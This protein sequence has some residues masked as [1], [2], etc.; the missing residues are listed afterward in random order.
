MA[1]LYLIDGNSLLFRAYY[2]TAYSGRLMQNSKGLYTN[3][4]YG[5]VNMMQKLINEGMDNVFVSFD[6][7]KQTFRHQMYDEYKA[8]RKHM[9]EEF[10][11]QLPYIRQY[12]DIVKICHYECLDFEGDDLIATVAKLA[13]DDYDDIRVITGDHDL[14]QLVD[15]KIKVMLTKK[16]IGELDEMN[17]DNFFEKNGFYPNQVTDY[18]GIAGDSS[19]HLLGV[20]GVGDKTAK[21]LLDQY[22]SL[23]GILG[24]LELLK[25]KQ[26]ELFTQYADQ[27]KMCQYLATLRKDA[28]SS[29][30]G[31]DLKRGTP[32]QKELLDFLAEMEFKSLANRL[33]NSD[34]KE[35][36]VVEINQIDLGDKWV[37]F[38][39]ISTLNEYN[40]QVLGV[41]IKNKAGSHFYTIEEIKANTSLLKDLAD[42]SIEKMTH[43]GKTTMISLARQGITLRGITE[44]S[45]LAAYLVN[46]SFADLDVTMCANHLSV[47]FSAL[48][49]EEI[50]MGSKKGEYSLD[51]I[52]TYALA[53]VDSYGALIQTLNQ[54]LQEEGAMKLYQ[55]EKELSQVLAAMEWTGLKVDLEKLESV[56]QELRE[57]ANELEKEIYNL[58]G[59]EFN[60][61]SPK[62]LSEVLFEKLGL[63]HGKKNK[64]GSF[65]TDVNVLQKL[66]EY[67]PIC[68]KILEYRGKEKLVQTYVEG[69]KSFS[70]VHDFIHP[71]YRQALT[72]TGR[73]SSVDPNIQNMPARTEEGQ[74]IR[75]VFV[76]RFPEGKIIDCDYSQ[77]ELRILAHLSEDP[78]MLEAFN[79]GTDFHASTASQIFDIPLEEVTKDMRRKAKIVNFGVI[80]GISS[81][82]LSDRLGM[83]NEEASEFI[84][85]YWANFAVAKRY[86]DGLVTTAQEKGYSETMLGRR[87][88]IP[89]LTSS[90]HAL[91]QFGERT[92]MNTPIQGSAADFIKVAMNKVQALLKEG[93]YKTVMIAQVHDELVFDSPK[94]E[95][96]I[97]M[98]LIKNC[99]ENA[100]P[101]KV[102]MAAES[103]IGANW[104]EA[105]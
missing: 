90:N 86:L 64:T 101:L 31:F 21:K 91:Q 65:K 42:A 44:D 58:A 52:K 57:K 50:F 100:M 9:P 92:A 28:L 104:L 10:A 13:Y 66:A 33:T 1:T 24:H 94:E 60:I 23:E 103:A 71:L 62:Q 83:S 5:F 48:H 96:E 84:N 77:I 4:I 19:D 102:K 8:G 39:V 20:P 40:G 78:K 56:G 76:S 81:W 6:A 82:G 89:K 15:K 25:G 97:V 38:P 18:K 68:A 3:A 36:K 72:T 88:Y 2:A 63:P 54:A 74:V 61:A 79:S 99:M 32:D 37:V 73:L 69:I 26:K 46:P 29:L 7:G 51:D 14:L 105:K 22:G 47:P 34:A 95:A 16:G 59:C 87:R 45:L 85:K 12:L 80:Y 70:D 35:H 67:Y 53:V 41:G 55:L 11:M 49:R 93:H 30:D 43:D 27:A 17:V 98:P 75:E